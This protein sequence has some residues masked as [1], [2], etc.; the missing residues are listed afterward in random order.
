MKD[1]VGLVLDKVAMGEVS[2]SGPA[3][4]SCLHHFTCS[5]LIFASFSSRKTNAQNLGN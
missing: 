4:C 5:L 2:S 3:A 1:Q